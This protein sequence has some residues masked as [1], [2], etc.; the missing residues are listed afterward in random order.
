MNG[1][2]GIH[3]QD[4]RI[5]ENDVDFFQAGNQKPDLTNVVMEQNKFDKD[6]QD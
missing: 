6:L 3:I 2:Q 4:S 1:A 5:T